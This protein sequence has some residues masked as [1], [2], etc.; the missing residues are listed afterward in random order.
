MF[1]ADLSASVQLQLNQLRD[2]TATANAAINSRYAN[3]ASL[4]LYANSASYAAFAGQAASASYA[5]LAATANSA[6][7][8][9]LAGTATNATIAGNAT[10]LGG[11]AGDAAATASTV[12][13]RNSSG[14]LFASYFSQ[15]SANNENPDIAAFLVSTAADSY[16]RKATLAYVE[17][18]LTTRNITGKTG[19]TKTLSTSAP[20]GGSD[21]DLWYR[22]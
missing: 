22:W 18:Y 20:S 15:S 19:V 17:T 1:N 6:S 8:A 7:Y 9:T 3:S 2:G 13:L 4:A 21:G 14:H 11:L 16:L 12:A 5:T 10:T